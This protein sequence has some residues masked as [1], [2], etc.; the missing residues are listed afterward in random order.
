[1]SGLGGGLYN[2]GAGTS[3][4]IANSIFCDNADSGGEDESAQIHIEGV[5]AGL[6]VDYS[7]VE[8][9]T[10]GLGGSGNIG[11]NPQFNNAAN[12]DYRL[13]DDATSPCVEAGDNSEVPFGVETDLDGAPRIVDGDGDLTATVDMGAYEYADCNGNDE[14]DAAE[15]PAAPEFGPL[16]SPARGI[17]DARKPHP[18]N[19]TEPC[20]GFGMPDDVATGVDESALYPI[21]IDLGVTGATGDCWTLCET[22]DMSTSDC[23]SNSITGVTDNTDGTYTIIL[24]HG[25]QGGTVTTIQY[26]GGYRYIEYVHHPASTDGS[27]RADANDIIEVVNCLNN[28]GT[29]E[30]YEADIDASGTQ[31]ANDI[32]EVVNLLNGAGA[33]DAWF[34]TSRPENTGDCPACLVIGSPGGVVGGEGAGGGCELLSAPEGGV[35]EPSFGP[36]F[37][38]FIMTADPADEAGMAEFIVTVEALT[39]WCA[40][41]LTSAEERGLIALLTDPEAEFASAAVEAM[42]PRIVAGLR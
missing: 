3:V 35:G 15:C 10:G 21:V 26:L 23:G 39:G 33:Y 38:A 20:Y 7:C 32:V 17:V 14:P 28:P 31:T 11:S 12:G 40:E 27:S 2:A 36:W 9:W 34:G 37:A 6:A 18:N 25:V 22:P 8:G 5:I 24:N 4:S 41:H 30:D 42:V 19:D 13:S 16:T 29:C 1:M